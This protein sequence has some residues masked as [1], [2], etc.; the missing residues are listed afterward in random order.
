MIK[1]LVMWKLKDVVEGADKQQNALKMKTILE[2]LKSKIAQIKH[3]EVG[4][5][6]IVSDAHYDV[7]LYSEFENETDLEIYQKH[8]EHVKLAVVINK[9][10][11]QRVVVDY[12]V[13]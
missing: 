12:K 5:N 1:H 4:S 8:P 2:A 10:T 11:E 3:I 7:A 6:I 9:M 13:G